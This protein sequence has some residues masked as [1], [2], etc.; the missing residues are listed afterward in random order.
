MAVRSARQVRPRAEWK[1]DSHCHSAVNVLSKTFKAEW[2]CALVR[3]GVS[4]SA[5]GTLKAEWQC[6]RS[7]GRAQRGTLAALAEVC[8]P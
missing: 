1:C 6:D 8:P 3:S 5:G 7:D 2:K 4:G